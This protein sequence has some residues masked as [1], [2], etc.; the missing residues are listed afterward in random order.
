MFVQTPS[1]VF[2]AIG[3]ATLS[4]FAIETMSESVCANYWKSLPAGQKPTISVELSKQPA[5]GR[6]RIDG[7]LAGRNTTILTPGSGACGITYTDDDKGAC[8]WGGLNSVEPIPQGQE[9]GWLT[10]SNTKNCGKSFFI[11]RGNKRA[12]GKFVDSCS[13]ADGPKLTVKQGCSTI[14]VT[15]ATYIDLGGNP[16]GLGRIQID[17]WDFDASTPPL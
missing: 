4:L 11:N 12:T 10:G 6:G 16:S 7:H 13:F 5:G 9:S 2:L 17:N 1:V 14:Y 3:I 8:L 15:L